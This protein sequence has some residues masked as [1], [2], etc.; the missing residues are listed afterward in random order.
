MSNFNEFQRAAKAAIRVAL[1][2]FFLAIPTGLICGLVG[3]LFH[4]SVERV[5]ELRADQPWLLFLLPAAGLLITALY[6]ATK[7]EGVGT[8][9]VIRAV[10]SG[11]PVSILLVPAIFFGTVLTH[12]CGGS[13]GRE[14]AALQ[15]GGSIGWNV[16]TLLHL[17][18]H[19]RRTATISGMA[20]FFSALFGTPLTAALFAMMVEDVGLTFTSAFVPAFTSALI[21]YGCSLAFGIAPTHFAITAPELTVWTAFL[22]ILLGFACA[23]VSRLFCG[24]LHFMEHKV[25]QLLP[26]PWLR[27]FVGGVA[28]IA[29]SYLFGVGRYNG[30]GMGVITAA[31][32]QGEALP[33]DFLCKIFLTALTLS[34]GFKGGE[35]VPSFFVGA[36]FG[37][38]FGPLLGLPAGFAAAVGLVSIFCG[39]TNALIPSILMGFELFSGAG[40]ELIALGCGICYMLSGHHGL[41]SSQT[42][43]TNKLR[44]EYMS[45]KLRHKVKKQEE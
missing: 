18:D 37:C 36:T 28:V 16:G 10:Q 25:P 22:V 20:A 13:A 34:C 2:W 43:V 3:T 38:V 45:H 1:Q 5:T 41:Y 39:A 21:A 29:F 31:V 4:L 32:E 30:A 35:V 7:C 11:E 44:S 27:V 8:N 12:L 17:K 33:W 42:F 24:L 19:D 40:L 14:G 15:M 9:N 23:A 26:N 6:K